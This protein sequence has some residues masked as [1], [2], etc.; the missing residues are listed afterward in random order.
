MEVA[1]LP[2]PSRTIVPASAARSQT[3]V[4]IGNKKL[5]SG[6]YVVK[7]RTTC[8]STHDRVD[9]RSARPCVRK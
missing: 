2:R 5:R 6:E 3:S 4:R 7:D 1:E 9:D 8:Q